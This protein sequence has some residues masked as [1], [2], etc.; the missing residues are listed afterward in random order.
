MVAH[1]GRWHSEGSSC[2]RCS[3]HAPRK[4][5]PKCI[6][7]AENLYTSRCADARSTQEQSFFLSLLTGFQ[8]KL[9]E[10]SNDIATFGHAQI[11]DRDETHPTP[12]PSP[13]AVFSKSFKKLNVFYTFC[14]F[15]APRDPQPSRAGRPPQVQPWLSVFY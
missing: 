9:Q 14:S 7:L 15:A 3:C 4:I 10:H 12:D 13:P 1:G 6:S 2:S 11:G 5:R 8:W